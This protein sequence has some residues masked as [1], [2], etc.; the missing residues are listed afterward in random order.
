MTKACSV[1]F[2]QPQGPSEGHEVSLQRGEEE[3]GIE[4]MIPTM[5]N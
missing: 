5:A 4:V 3:P 2:P 1:L